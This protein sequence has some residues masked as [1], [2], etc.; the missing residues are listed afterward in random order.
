M[1]EA[2]RLRG[3]VFGALGLLGLAMAC[4]GTAAQGKGDE[5]SS[6]GSDTSGKGG[7]S[8]SGGGGAFGRGGSP[9]PGGAAGYSGDA[10]A[11]NGG[12]GNYGGG[13][14]GSEGGVG[15]FGGTGANLVC[16]DQCVTC[17]LSWGCSY[18][19]PDD[20]GVINDGGP[21][22]PICP[23]QITWSGTS[24]P[25]WLKHTF[26]DDCCYRVCFPAGTGGYAGTGSD[27]TGG[28]AGTF[29]DA[30]AD[31][32]G[33]YAGT[34]GT[35]GYGL[36]G[37]GGGRPYLVEGRA[38]TA[39]PAWRGDWSSKAAPDLDALGHTLRQKLLEGWLADARLEHASVAAFARLTLE[40]L[41]LGAPPD[42]IEGSQ[43]A[44][45][46]EI[47]HARDCFAL[48]SA[49]AGAPIGPGGLA[50][51]GALEQSSLVE[52]AVRTVHEGCVGE[53]IAALVA[54]A[55]LRG[56]TDPAVRAALRRIARDEA[57]HAELSWRVVA[58]A[59]RAGGPDVA[60]AVAHAFAQALEAPPHVQ[61]SD[62]AAADRESFRAHGRLTPAELAEV[63]KEALAEVVAPCAAALLDG[64]SASDAG[65]ERAAV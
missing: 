41:A 32:A 35:G 26:L 25:A 63:V 47:E 9:G 29:V 46:D 58:W 39:T 44:S 27:G 21:I 31:S 13:G 33:G 30:G 12:Y 45:L 57:Q 1:L 20:A 65:C 19:E 14:V 50:L 59:L 56:A 17:E 64:A 48:A 5:P 24:I 7:N 4:G 51:E 38:R 28:Y 54:S 55:A 10:G 15:G 42:L 23:Q 49:Y 3:R 62:V 34:W 61:G 36:G 40:L 52:L 53:T 22:N 11:S 8:G 43:R 18:P 37:V 60:H 2:Q 16:S 6:G